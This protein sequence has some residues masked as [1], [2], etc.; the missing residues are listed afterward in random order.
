MKA[1]EYYAKYSEQLM[2]PDQQ[3]CD[4]ALQA[5]I[6][7]F[8][9]EATDMMTRRKASSAKSTIAIIDELNDK[10]NSICDRFPH[11][12]LI[13]NGYRDFWYQ[14][15]GITKSMADMVRKQRGT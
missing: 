8:A 15:L 6:A 2:S 11:E 4:A 14:Q 3:V 13:R 10:W 1:R 5:L 9:R 7:D 12:V